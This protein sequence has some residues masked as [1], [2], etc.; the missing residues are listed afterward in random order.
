MSTKR[1]RNSID[2]DKKFKIIQLVEKK[3]PYNEIMQKHGLKNLAN[4]SR[5]MQQKEKIIKAYEE[6][7]NSKRKN[8]KT[9][10]YGQVEESLKQFISNCNNN[11]ITITQPII[12]E[13]AKEYASK[14]G[15]NNFKGSNG[16]FQRFKERNNVYLQPIHGESSNVPENI[17]QEW[18]SRFSSLANGYEP[19][20]IFNSD[21]L[22]LFYRLLPNKTFT[23]KGNKCRSGKKSKERITILIGSNMDGSEKLK[24]AVIGHSQKPRCFKNVKSLPVIYKFNRKAWMTT[25]LFKEILVPFNKK[26]LK[27]NRNILMFID[28]SPAHG[29]QTFSNKVC[30]F[31]TKY[32]FM[33]AR[34]YQVF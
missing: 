22:G 3:V 21:E 10:P 19:K 15:F 7:F 11:G 28:N 6:G 24:L 31:S 17:I 30:I 12:Q 20:D 13:K 33:S 18:K 25:E 4:I 2:L 26:L 29:L 1:S 14:I 5:I 16:F 27:E 9:T 34:D 8:L 32:Y 23:V